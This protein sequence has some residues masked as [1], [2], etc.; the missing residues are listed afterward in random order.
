MYIAIIKVEANRVT[1]YMDYATLEEAQ[2][3]VASYD[4]VVAAPLPPDCGVRDLWVEGTTV[5]VVPYTDPPPP[6]PGTLPANIT[7]DEWNALCVAVL[8]PE[9]QK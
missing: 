6:D 5:T 7:V 1:K 9:M 4:G 3:H 2:A 8:H